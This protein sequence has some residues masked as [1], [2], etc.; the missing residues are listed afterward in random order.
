MAWCS[1]VCNTVWRWCMYVLI[2]SAVC[3]TFGVCA[4]VCVCVC[5]C[6]WY[7]T[8]TVHVCSRCCVSV[9]ACGVVCLHSQ[10]PVLVAKQFEAVYPQHLSEYRS[11]LLHCL[12]NKS[13]ETGDQRA[14]CL[15]T[16]PP[17][18]KCHVSKLHLSELRLQ[19]RVFTLKVL[20]M[21]PSMTI[22]MC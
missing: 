18:L 7:M 9:C 14:K 13:V 11:L 15:K 12:S 3:T 17:T 16:W 8:Y 10:W 21:S 5:A 2:V 20:P 19:C 1:V 6:V 4:C 22:S